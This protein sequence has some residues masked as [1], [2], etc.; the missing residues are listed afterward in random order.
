[1]RSMKDFPTNWVTPKDELYIIET[2]W[3]NAKVLATSISEKDGGSHQFSGR[4]S[5]AR[6]ASLAP[7]TATATRRLLTRPSIVYWCEE[8]CGPQA[9]SSNYSSTC[10]KIEAGLPVAIAYRIAQIQLASSL[11][12]TELWQG[13]RWMR[14]PIGRGELANVVVGHLELRSDLGIRLT[15]SLE[16]TT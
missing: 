5:M 7:P 1:M 3:P 13:E 6:L 8:F 16:R 4:T 14:L 2:V 11:S 9:S 10:R 12:S 15:V